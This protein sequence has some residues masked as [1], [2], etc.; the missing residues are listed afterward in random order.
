MI[1]DSDGEGSFS[2]SEAAQLWAI[3]SWGWVG[4]GVTEQERVLKKDQTE[5]QSFRGK[6]LI[7][8]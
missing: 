6:S 4:H 8:S 7:S 3:G 5:I 2:S 1:T